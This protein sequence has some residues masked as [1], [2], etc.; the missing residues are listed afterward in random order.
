ML[1]PLW[2][3]PFHSDVA[4]SRLSSGAAIDKGVVDG[5]HRGYKDTLAI[6][7][8]EEGALGRQVGVQGQEEG[9]DPS[10]KK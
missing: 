3:V 4:A 8:C 7:L 6:R 9:S 2:Q 5:V 10:V 1:L